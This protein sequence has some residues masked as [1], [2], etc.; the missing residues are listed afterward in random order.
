MLLG[1]IILPYLPPLSEGG[2]E[3]SA[4]FRP[5]K[6]GKRQG[7]MCSFSGAKNDT[8]VFLVGLRKNSN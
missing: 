1:T 6:K 2:K 8:F 3:E 5:I 4:L 7:A